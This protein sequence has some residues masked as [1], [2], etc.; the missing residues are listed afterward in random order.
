MALLLPPVA[1]SF[2]ASPRLYAARNLDMMS[3][4]SIPQSGPRIYT[5]RRSILQEPGSV[6]ILS[7]AGVT[8]GC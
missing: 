3:T 1:G 8:Y 4:G 5:E 7:R 2:D 6:C